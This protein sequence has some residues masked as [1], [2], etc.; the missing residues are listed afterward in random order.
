[1]AKGP[2]YLLVATYPSKDA[3]EADYE[4]VWKLHHTG[5]IGDLRRRGRHA[6]R[7]RQ[8]PRPQA[9]E[10]HAARRLDG[11]R[12]GRGDRPG[13]PSGDDRHCAAVGAWPAVWSPTW[14]GHVAQAGARTSASISSPGRRRWWSSARSSSRT[15]SATPCTSA[16]RVEEHEIQADAGV[17]EDTIKDAGAD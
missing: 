1:M 2:I 10:D 12:R 6:R 3:A 16:E 15:C 5:R 11:H 7:R 8:D 14:E 17:L 13:V 9:R 4:A